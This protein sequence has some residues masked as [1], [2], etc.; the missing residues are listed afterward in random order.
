VG[1]FLQ[2]LISGNVTAVVTTF[3]ALTS[4]EEEQVLSPGQLLWVNVATL[5]LVTDTASPALLYCKPNKTTGPLFTINM[6]KQIL[7]QAMY[8]IAMI[9][10]FHFLRSQILV[11]SYRRFYSTGAS[12][13][14]CADACFQCVYVRADL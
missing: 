6:T 9:L 8:Q 7:G 12:R 14:N 3:W 2:F 1:K 11:P 10:I 5:A 4:S 13:R